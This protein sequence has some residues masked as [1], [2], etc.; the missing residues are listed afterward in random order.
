MMD[1]SK[2]CEILN[3]HIFEGEKRELLKKVADRPER[4]IGLFRPSKPG[5]KILQHLLQSHE[6]RFGDALEELIEEILKDLGYS[7]LPKSITTGNGEQLSLDQFFTDGENYYFIEQ[8]IRDDHDSTKKRGQIANFEAKLEELFKTYKNKLIGIMYFID[9]DLVKNKNFY[10]SE[11]NRLNEYYKVSLY[12]FYGKEL[13]EFL[14]SPE[15]WGRLLDWLTRWKG[16]LPEIPEINFDTTPQDSFKEIKNLEIR[17]WRKLLENK[18]L[19]EEGIIKA[20]FRSGKT[21]RLIL[22]YF[23]TQTSAPYQKLSKLLRERLEEYY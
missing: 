6:I 11:L 15:Y 1:Y 4:F 22:N 2:F 8:K 5:T 23:T 13:F 19:W 7:I 16:S 10:I 21:L 3:K 14:K 20:I 18:K 9:P 17:Y 12:L